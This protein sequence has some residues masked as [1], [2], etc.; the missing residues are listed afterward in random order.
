MAFASFEVPDNVAVIGAKAFE[1][2]QLQLSTTRMATATRRRT[3]G[4]DAGQLAEKAGGVAEIAMATETTPATARRSKSS[5]SC[6]HIECEDPGARTMACRRLPQIIFDDVFRG[7]QAQRCERQRR[8]GGRTGGERAA[9]DQKKI[10]V[11]VG[12]LEL[13]HHRGFW[14]IAHPAGSHDVA[15]A[16][17][18]SA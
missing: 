12:A 7:P 15:G 1:I 8:V 18:S 14:I 13:V 10:L 5:K 2:G 11:I 17:C 16:E 9:A 4:D 3:E 6:H